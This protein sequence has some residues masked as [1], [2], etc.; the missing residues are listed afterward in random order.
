M[1]QLASGLD[2]AFARLADST[3]WGWGENTGGQLG[4]GANTTDQHSTVEITGLSNI[5]AVATGWN[6]SIVVSTNGVASTWGTNASSQ[7]GEGTT[8]SR[9][10]PTPISDTGYAWRVA[11]PT[12][13]VASGTYSVDKT[14]VVSVDT[15]GATIH[16]TQNGTD[17]TETDPTVASGGSVTV[18]YSQTLKA[19][20]WKTGMPAGE[21]ASAT[22][23][24]QVATP[25]VSPTATTYTS[26]QNVTMSTTTPG[27]TLR[28]TIDGTDPTESST[29]YTGAIATANTR[30]Y[31]IIGFKSGWTPSAVRV[32]TY[33]MNFG[34]LA[35][36]SVD[37]A[38][39]AYSG[40]VSVTMSSPQSGA[41]IRYTTNNTAPTSGSPVYS[42]AIVVGA[43]TTIRAKVFH[44]DYT[45]SAETSRT[46]TLTAHTP[47]LS[48]VAG[49][50]AP[51]S[52]VTITAGAP[53]TDT[54]RMTIDG[55]DPTTTSPSIASGITIFL[56]N[57]TLK[58][59]A[60]RTGATDSAIASVAYGLTAPLGPGSAAAGGTHSIIATPDGRLIAWGENLNGQIGNQSTVDRTTATTLNTITGVTQLAGGLAHTLARTWDNQVYAWG[61]NGSGRLGDGTTTQ[62]TR[63]T[64]ITTLS[65][66]V[67]VAAGDAHSLALTSGGLVFA[68][69]E[70]A[71]GQL[72]LGSTTDT[73][74]PTQIPS[75]TNIVAIATG[76]LHSLALDAS[77][78]IFAWGLNAN[79]RLGDGTTTQR[80]SP[81]PITLA[82]VV[83]IAAG[84][85]HSLAMTSSG[86]VHPWGLNTNGQLGLGNTT[87]AT[88]PTVIPALHASA[89]A[90][91]DNFSAV[92]R[93]DGVLVAFGANTSGQIGDT[94]TTQRTSPVVVSGPASISS[95]AL[96]DT[97]SLVVTPGAE[98]WT[99]GLGASGQLGDG[100]IANR[101]TPQAVLT[102]IA[103]WSAAAPTI[104]LPSGSFTS[105]QTV[106]IDSSTPGASIRYTL[107]GAV[108]T[109]IDAEVPAGG[110]V[111]I[112]SPSLLRARAFVSGREAGGVGRAD[113][114]LRPATP[115][116]TPGTALYTAAQ[117]VVLSSST[118]DSVLRYSIDGTDPTEAST[119]YTS[120]FVVATLTTVKARAFY[121]G[122]APSAIAQASFTFT[123]DPPVLT[124]E[125][126]LEGA[127]TR[128]A[129]TTIRGTATDAETSITSVTCN[130]TPFA[131]VSGTFTCTL[132]LQPGWNMI[133]VQAA[134][135]HG[136]PT[137]IT[138]NV[139]YET[140]LTVRL[141]SP[142]GVLSST[143]ATVGAEVYG[144]EGEPIT[145][146][147][148][149]VGGAPVTLR[150]TDRP[151]VSFLAP[152][153]NETITLRLDVSNTVSTA[154]A[155]VDVTTEDFGMTSGIQAGVYGDEH[156]STLAVGSTSLLPGYLWS[157]PSAP[158]AVT[159]STDDGA[160]LDT[161]LT[162]Q[163][164]T[165]ALGSDE[166]SIDV[167]AWF[168][169]DPVENVITL[170]PMHADAFR[171]S[172]VDTLTTLQISGVDNQ[173]RN[174]ALQVPLRLARFQIAGT[175]TAPNGSLTGVP[176]TVV[177][178]RG[179]NEGYRA[180]A[181]AGA[182]G[183]FF[184][185]GVFADEYFLTAISPNGLIVVSPLSLDTAAAD[186]QVTSLQMSSPLSTIV[187]LTGVRQ[188]WISAQGGWTFHYAL[189]IPQGSRRVR[190]QL[191]I[192][193]GYP[194]YG[195]YSPPAP[196]NGPCVDLPTDDLWL[197]DSRFSYTFLLNGQV[198]TASSTSLCGTGLQLQPSLWPG[199]NSPGFRA[200]YLD[201][202]IDV[203]AAASQGPATLTAFTN[204]VN[205]PIPEEYWRGPGFGY[206]A[207]A[208]VLY[209]F[210]TIS[211]VQDFTLTQVTDL[212]GV[213]LSPQ[214]APCT[215]P[216]ITARLN[217]GAPTDTS[218]FK[219]LG[220][221]VATKATFQKPG[222]DVRYAP[223]D[224]T[225]QTIRVFVEDSGGRSEDL[226]FTQPQPAANGWFTLTSVGF[227]TA[228]SRPLWDNKSDLVNVYVEVQA[229]LPN[230]TPVTKKIKL[231][232]D[233]VRRPQGLDFRPLYDA[234]DITGA[235]ARR[236]S[237]RES[238]W[239][240]DG[241]ARRKTYDVLRDFT[242]I[243]FNDASLEHGGPFPPHATHGTG[244]AF[245]ARYPGVGGSGNALN[246]SAATRRTTL[247]QARDGDLASRQQIVDW[248]LQVREKLGLLQNDARVSRVLIGRGIRDRLNNRQTEHWNYNAIIGGRYE[249][250]PNGTAPEIINPATGLAIGAWTNTKLVRA[251]GHLDHI[252]VDVHK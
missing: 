243:L 19:R 209:A 219:I 182:D 30:T 239:G 75:L 61:S 87:T 198:V 126:P 118:P 109:I 112:T 236:F 1:A 185:D 241:W 17:P 186:V 73:S 79:S 72:G 191:Q 53:S 25:T 169:Y 7:L 121:S 122:W 156:Q 129:S 176:G 242:W 68:W 251:D 45:T 137:T 228:A 127:V 247:T 173:G 66:V 226:T 92:L 84:S 177:L 47:T 4:L 159:L 205:P 134:D 107:N 229:L 153:S 187:G 154:T 234:G 140:S 78:Q 10:V 31:R 57:F 235:S 211:G 215:A 40:S 175:V 135:Q 108:P 166:N 165:L 33:T 210:T 222:I 152:N 111:A 120:S 213:A 163:P 65:N 32:A 200:G 116:I 43:T 114:E 98:V 42:S 67:A 202:D 100:G 55:S 22:Y 27:S 249:P 133:T 69:G 76:D 128:N 218:N 58:V 158:F 26:P 101:S 80:T 77:G 207:F 34:T 240:L 11:T 9:S 148:T 195:L 105:E 192:D 117:T 6:H 217:T 224:A 74:V 28:Y 62:R 96:G 246:T 227:A 201:M 188:G 35:A 102:G 110:Q 196:G 125:D 167:T 164:I 38:T 172:V 143:L 37:P 157:G 245:D 23:T 221:P 208:G 248:I 44:P 103:G 146:Q 86:A 90:A 85:A 144:P 97:H 162:E 141:D 189:Q 131:V 170:Q 123:Y 50:Y 139:K 39:G 56:G 83:A 93:G 199:D 216:G 174:V 238:T 20:A 5:A 49:S 190:L 24:M 223:A 230:K 193:G 150:Y 2:H 136:N 147:W 179:A 94:T 232:V 237:C 115:T 184:I 64:L 48:A 225:I 63:P 13:N 104:N 16:Y 119:V 155:N 71:N 113:Y 46:Y 194:P 197:V 168:T 204:G 52:T 82:N 81:V 91:G 88:T 41:T 15:A 29:A 233:P 206:N 142:V 171:A 212:P 12:F 95:L 132:Q 106:T 178:L 70:N 180:S 151:A 124:V 18:T 181:I 14:V 244:V 51:G 203:R 8:A 130:G 21:I 250:L 99:W 60:W 89:I 145:Y 220:I 160:T 231:G 138:R 36:P 59:K 3:V 161:S 214:A 252:H 54:L 183:S 149:Q